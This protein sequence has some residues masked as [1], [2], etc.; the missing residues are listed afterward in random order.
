MMIA[1][2]PR[3]DTVE[4]SLPHAALAHRKHGVGHRDVD[5]LS[6]AGPPRMVDRRQHAEAQHHARD[7]VAH[8][9]PDLRR[10]R[11]VGAGDRHDAAHRLRDD[12]ERRPI[13]IGG[14]PG[15]RVA[16]TAQASID[17]PRVDR[18]Q[19]VPAQTQPVHDTRAEVLDHG[20]GV[21]DQ[22]LQRPRAA[23]SLEIEDDAVLVAPDALEIP[24][25]LPFA[26][27]LRPSGRGAAHVAFGALDLD[28]L[29]TLIG[30]HHR[31]IGPG[32]HLRQVDD[33]DVGQRSE[34]RRAHRS[35]QWLL[36][37][38]STVRSTSATSS[39]CWL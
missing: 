39:S 30:E 4:R 22:R 32:Q 1:L 29:C 20:V 31:A 16:E 36:R 13:L 17:E 24:R 2:R 5:D 23:L 28:D 9:R 10:R 27:G 21:A 15:T 35:P 11:G 14:S 6:L 33:P 7:D 8:P 34:T 3:Q 25:K 18:A 12:V 26:G 19:H 38:S 37:F